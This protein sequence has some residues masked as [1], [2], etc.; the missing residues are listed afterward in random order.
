MFDAQR[1]LS[2]REE[3]LRTIIEMADADQAVRISV[4]AMKEGEVAPWRVVAEIACG[5]VRERT[6]AVFRQLSRQVS[7]FLVRRKIFDD[8]IQWQHRHQIASG[9]IIQQTNRESLLLEAAANTHGRL[10]FFSFVIECHL[11]GG[12]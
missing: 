11:R 4:A 12:R 2:S 10:S 3:R 6:A 9:V 1:E 8:E 5:F 7:D